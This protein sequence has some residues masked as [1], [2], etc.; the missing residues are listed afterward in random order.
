LWV[1][2]S[3][4]EK[5][6]NLYPN[7]IISFYSE[8]VVEINGLF[9]SFK[10]LKNTFRNYI[11]K[12]HNNIVL[13]IAGGEKNDHK[14]IYKWMLE[15][16][17]YNAEKKTDVYRFSNIFD[18]ANIIEVCL[19][20]LLYQQKYIENNKIYLNNSKEY[21]RFFILYLVSFEEIAG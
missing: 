6:K 10:D 4:S 16:I 2:K 17:K 13:E 21:F 1:K 14:Y 8:N 18:T 11:L 5:D 9:T 20:H 12:K 19:E 3:F 7:Q 15:D